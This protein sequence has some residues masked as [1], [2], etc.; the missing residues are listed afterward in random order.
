MVMG[1]LLLKISVIELKRSPMVGCLLEFCTIAKN[2]MLCDMKL[3]LDKGEA[4]RK[5]M[6][7]YHILT[8]CNRA[9]E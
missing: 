5:M 4:G 3:F 1:K 2:Q 9:C 6:K 7:S 8:T